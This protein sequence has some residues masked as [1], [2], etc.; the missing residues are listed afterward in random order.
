MHKVFTSVLLIASYLILSGCSSNKY[1]S[2]PA[3]ATF[4][5]DGDRSEWTGRFQI[6]RGEK[7]AV[8]LSHDKNYAYVAISSMDQDFQRQLAM[9]GLTLWLDSKGGKHRTLGIKYQGKLQR[10]GRQRNMSDRQNRS[11]LSDNGKNRIREALLINGELDL[12]VLDKNKRERL[13]P[14]D[15]FASA[16]SMNGSLFI[17]YQIPMAL[18]APGNE[19]GDQLGVGIESTFEKP[20]MSGAMTKGGRGGHGG[21]MAGGM[22]G[23]QRGGGQRG[24]GRQ[25]T[26]GRPSTGLVDVD[27]WLKVGLTP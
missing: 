16:N 25:G 8:A 7:F 19:I 12:V 21:G 18:I 24:G 14:N 26:T 27:V 23:G 11:A 5:N 22:S 4:R 3:D 13:G 9:G 6:P 15:L 1:L 10:D 2:L 20:E 17:E